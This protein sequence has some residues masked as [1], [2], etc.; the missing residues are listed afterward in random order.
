[1]RLL[2]RSLFAIAFIAFIG[3]VGTW[4]GQFETIWRVFA[5]AI[6]VL[7]LFEFLDAQSWPLQ[8]KLD[9][10][11]QLGLGAYHLATLS[12][13]NAGRKSR[14]FRFR[15]VTPRG[16][17]GDQKDHQA[18][19]R[20][21]HIASENFELMGTRLGEH[22]WPRQPVE[23][24]G[25]LGFSAWIR[26]VPIETMSRVVPDTAAH[27]R[28]RIGAI[29]MGARRDPIAMGQ[30]DELRSL[31]DYAPGDP[32]STIDWKV[33][34][35]QRRLVVRELEADRHIE[36]I[37][38]L[39]AGQASS[40]AC[41]KL[42]LLGHY[43][44]VAARLAVTAEA[45]GDRYGLVVFADR[46]YASLGIGNGV[47]HQRKLHNTLAAV[48]SSNAAANP[49]PAMVAVSRM[50]ERRSLIVLFTQ[51]DH[52]Q[53]D[54]QLLQATTLLRPKHLPLLVA[55]RDPA[56]AQLENRTAQHW[57]DPYVSLAASEHRQDVIAARQ[58]LSRLGANVIEAEPRELDARVLNRYAELRRTN[59]V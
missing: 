54:G 2:P 45:Y 48:R 50:A 12:L 8:L 22:D 59:R 9:Q 36:I 33:S 10:P 57:L 40:L 49:L 46:V 19:L 42:T 34:A 24:I 30:G 23:I 35:R 7:I 26:R 6:V 52:A 3:I 47:G 4:L 5:V 18:T 31:R 37:F 14:T 29:D 27:R 16:V 43:A 41:E 13:T 38:A 56:V 21:G 51:L 55:V 11:N 1:M 44:N 25:L 28:S 17:G 58:R 15:P 20:P 32:P 53:A 39:D